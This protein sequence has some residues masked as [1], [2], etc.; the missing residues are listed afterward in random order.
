MNFFVQVITALAILAVTL[1]TSF[2][3][4]ALPF[5]LYYTIKDK[6][7]GIRRKP[8][9]YY[10]LLFLRSLMVHFGAIVGFVLCV[11]LAALTARL[12]GAEV[13]IEVADN[14][15]GDFI[16]THRENLPKEK[17][18]GLSRNSVIFVSTSVEEKYGGRVLIRAYDNA[19]DELEDHF[20]LKVVETRMINRYPVT[21]LRWLGAS[22]RREDVVELRDGTRKTVSGLSWWIT[23]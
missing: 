8:M 17:R 14:F 11:A 4:A 20:V 15:A 5:R 2:Y 16:R 1:F 19:E 12:P 9:D 7:V 18:D 6:R 21:P 22:T 23:I 13:K 10:G 3:L